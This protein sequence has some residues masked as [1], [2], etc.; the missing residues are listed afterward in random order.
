MQAFAEAHGYELRFVHRDTCPRPRAWLKIEVIRAMLEDNFDFVF[1]MDVDAIVLR[2]DVDIRTAAVGEASLYMAWHGP[3]TSKIVVPDFIPHFNSGVM[4]IRVNDWSRDF[5]RR[6]WETGQLPHHWFDQATIHHLLGYDECLG[7]G[8]DRPHEPDRSHLARLDTAWNSVPGLATAPD[9]LVHHYAGISNPSTRIRLLEADAMTAAL[10]EHAGAELRQAFSRQ[11]SH[12]RE[13]ATMRDWV[14][15][16]RDSALA[17]LQAVA[18]ERLG[19]LAERDGARA[20]LAAVQNS[21]SWRLTAP[22]RWTSELFRR[23]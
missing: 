9:P 8:P 4:L 2:N 17:A 18:A 5:F 15:A 6:V 10:R 20:Q 13:D 16:E 1:W 23:P 12:W 21:T 22:L 3:E 14:T 11:F 19:C 7:L